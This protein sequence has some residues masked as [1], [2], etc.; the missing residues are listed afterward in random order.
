MSGF[1]PEDFYKGAVHP[2]RDDSDNFEVQAQRR[3]KELERRAAAGEALSDEDQQLLKLSRFLLAK[4][5]AKQCLAKFQGSY[6]AIRYAMQNRRLHEAAREHFAQSNSAFHAQLLF[7][8][9]ERVYLEY[10]EACEAQR[11]RLAREA[12]AAQSSQVIKK[13]IEHTEYSC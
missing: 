13:R 10:E 7:M 9:R 6:A 8:Q 5:E 12:E 1:S 2:E 11:L 3:G 4:E